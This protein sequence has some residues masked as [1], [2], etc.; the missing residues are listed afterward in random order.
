MRS[1][2]GPIGVRFNNLTGH[3]SLGYDIV[4][5]DDLIEE[6]KEYFLNVLQLTRSDV[7]PESERRPTGTN[8]AH[9]PL[10]HMP[11]A[12]KTPNDVGGVLAAEKPT[13]EACCF[14]NAY[15]TTEDKRGDSI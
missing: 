6:I 7:C 1:I 10:A 9:L 4:A 13:L 12:G 8:S 3:I 2:M 11:I 5:D 14:H 15:V